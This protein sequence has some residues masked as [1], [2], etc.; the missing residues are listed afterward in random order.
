MNHVNAQDGYIFYMM[1]VSLEL[2]ATSAFYPT[3]T[4]PNSYTSEGDETVDDNATSSSK[5]MFNLL[6]TTNRD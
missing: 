6:F 5:S 2:P 3:G 4:P 1:A